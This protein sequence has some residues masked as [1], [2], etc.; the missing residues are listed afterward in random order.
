MCFCSGLYS[1]GVVCRWAGRVPVARLRRTRAEG[2]GN[3]AKIA[4]PT[5]QIPRHLTDVRLGHKQTLKEQA[6]A[7]NDGAL[8]LSMR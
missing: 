2:Y 4:S 5:V 3:V 7:Q 1:W 8:T 6:S